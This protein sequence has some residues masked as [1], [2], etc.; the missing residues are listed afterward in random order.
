MVRTSLSPLPARSTTSTVSTRRDRGCG[1]H[2]RAR[3]GRA[4]RAWISVTASERGRARATGRSRRWRARPVSA[5]CRARRSGRVDR[6]RDRRRVGGEAVDGQR[7]AGRWSGRPRCRPGSIA[8]RTL[9]APAWS[10][11]IVGDVGDRALATARP[12][13]A[14]AA[15]RR[16]ASSAVS[17]ASKIAPKSRVIAVPSP[18]RGGGCV[19][20]TRRRSSPFLPSSPSP[21]TRACGSR[22]AAMSLRVPL[23]TPAA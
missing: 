16:R 19:S 2:R 4:R 9:A 12:R 21:G 15:R 17:R 22:P 8:G 1:R 14:R 3:R 13:A 11:S 6:D 7:E 5:R 10:H 18:V 23:T 20:S